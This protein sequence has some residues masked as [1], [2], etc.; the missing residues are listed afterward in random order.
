ME[1]LRVS[2]RSMI[3]SSLVIYP[4]VYYGAPI[5]GFKTGLDSALAS[6]YT[7]KIEKIG[8][9]YYFITYTE[10]GENTIIVPI[11]RITGISWY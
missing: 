7:W 1:N 11:P 6:V 2:F 10:N 9:G 8:G 5:A 4:S 3:D